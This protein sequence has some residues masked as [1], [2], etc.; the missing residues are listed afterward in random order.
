MFP[1]FG[2]HPGDTLGDVSFPKLIISASTLPSSLRNTPGPCRWAPGD[3]A[4]V[5]RARWPQMTEQ[6]VST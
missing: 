5:M 3:S 6:E 2:V 1:E 4:C